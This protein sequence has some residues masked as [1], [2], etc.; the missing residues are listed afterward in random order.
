MIDYERAD[1]EHPKQKA[2]LTRA[3]NAWK[4]NPDFAHR[5][6]VVEVVAKA[7]KEWDEWNAWPDDW[8]RWNIAYQDVTGTFYDIKEVF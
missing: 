2:A 3:M 4:K 8:H 5:K 6:R 1:K 7:V